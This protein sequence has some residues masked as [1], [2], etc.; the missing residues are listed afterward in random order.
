MSPWI[1][2]EPLYPGVVPPQPSTAESAGLDAVAHLEGRTV[3]VYTGVDT[4]RPGKSQPSIDQQGPQVTLW[5]GWRVAI[6]LG[7]K[8]RLPEGYE[9]QV[10]S[11]SGLALKQ[12][13]IVLNAPGTIDS[14]YPGEW[15]VI[16]QNTS[17]APVTI[18]HGDRIAQLVLAPV[19][20]LDWREGRVTQVSDRAGG[21]GSTG[22]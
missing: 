2:F 6:P 14:D 13:L 18:A 11:R 4:T 9:M 19:I 22:V 3:A 20:R 12:G 5:G 8:A 16:L 21:F 1:A 15:A 17:R 7:F 10:R